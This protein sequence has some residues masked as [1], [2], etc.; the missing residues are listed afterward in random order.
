MKA[1]ANRFNLK[2]ASFEHQKPLK[3]EY[4][5]MLYNDDPLILGISS[6]HVAEIRMGLVR[7]QIV[8]ESLT[9]V[10]VFLSS[11]FKP[12]SKYAGILS[13]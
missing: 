9:R 3:T 12:F 11:H 7:F 4:I 8:R 2:T 13:T 6:L 5:S 10:K 1:I